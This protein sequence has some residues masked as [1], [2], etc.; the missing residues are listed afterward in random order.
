MVTGYEM[1]IFD[2]EDISQSISPGLV[3][4]VWSSSL[5]NNI[6]RAWYSKAEALHAMIVLEDYIFGIIRAGAG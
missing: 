6:L 3:P 5:A 2:K 4:N 1:L